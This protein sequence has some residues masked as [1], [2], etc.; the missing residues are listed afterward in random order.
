MEDHEE[1]GV[2]FARIQLKGMLSFGGGEEDNLVL[3]GFYFIAN[4]PG[5]FG[6]EGL[7]LFSSKTSDFRFA[8][9]FGSPYVRDNGTNMAFVPGTDKV[10][11]EKLFDE[12]YGSR[13]VRV[14]VQNEGYE[15]ASTVNDARGG[16]VGCIA[17][18]KAKAA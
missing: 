17:S 4:T 2:G 13:Q 6:A 16:S 14:V 8:H 10:D 11:L 12:L 9:L 1:R 15:L 3:A 5:I 18:I 7:A